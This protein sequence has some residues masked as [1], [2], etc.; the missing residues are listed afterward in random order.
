MKRV[1]VKG[2]SFPS[3][4]GRFAKPEIKDI[5]IA[6]RVVLPLVPRLGEMI[7]IVSA[8]D[9][10]KAGQIIARGP[11]KWF[12][13][14]L[15]GVSGRIS[16]ITS[17]ATGS[18][19]EG[20]AIV[21]ESA[22]ADTPPVRDIASQ[23]AIPE[24]MRWIQ[25]GDIREVDPSP[26][27]LALRLRK[28]DLVPSAFGPLSSALEKPI[29]TLIINGIDRQPG[30]WIRKALIELYGTEIVQCVPLL[31]GATGASRVVLAVSKGSVFS[32]EI[33][34]GL[35]D[36]GVEIVFCPNIYHIGLEPLLVPFLTGQQIPPNS[37]ARDF[38]IVILDVATA[39]KVHGIARG[40]S[41]SM[42][43]IVQVTIPSSGIDTL[44]KVREG[45]LIE[46]ILDGL[47]ISTKGLASL[48]LKS[49]LY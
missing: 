35:Q 33:L 10:I 47:S 49:A 38:G 40:K 25:A 16:S 26:L 41:P 6:E 44:V 2:I 12:P 46:D 18:G 31:K 5:P 32:E 42:D 48:S 28:P 4:N 24:V 45:T 8:G 3:E 43:V 23:E 9:H 29:H 11:Q 17:W 14:L 1:K 39:L 37:G 21:I 19:G 30:V 22:S 27:P 15:A 34:Q 7:P 36:Q 13:P 20:P